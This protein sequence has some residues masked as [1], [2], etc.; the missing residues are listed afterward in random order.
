M[1]TSNRTFPW[2]WMAL[3]SLLVSCAAPQAPV[4]TTPAREYQAHPLEK[5][6]AS[7]ESSAESKVRE[8][9]QQ[10]ADALGNGDVK[11]YAEAMPIR[12]FLL[13]L[14]DHST[15]DSNEREI[16]WQSYHKALLTKMSDDARS[17]ASSEIKIV[18]LHSWGPGQDTIGAV[19][20]YV[21]ENSEIN[22][23]EW[24]FVRDNLQTL[25]DIR[26]FYSGLWL[27]ESLSNLIQLLGSSLGNKVATSDSARAA[28]RVLW[29]V[30]SMVKAKDYS[31][32]ARWYLAL[33]PKQ[34]QSAFYRGLTVE[35]L[36]GMPEYYQEKVITT[37]TQN[38]QD[39]GRYALLLA[40][41]WTNHGQFAKGMEALNMLDPK[42]G[43][44]AGIHLIRARLYYTQKQYKQSAHYF[45]MALTH[46]K[47][48]K[49]AW[50]ELLEI[51]ALAEEWELVAQ[52][53][54]TLPGWMDLEFDEKVLREQKS[55]QPFFQ[56]EAYR[57]Y[58]ARK[59]MVTEE[60]P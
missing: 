45:A 40:Q 28:Q 33:N 16:V 34:Q 41:H 47:K 15:L 30:T 46:D 18:S 10:I 14:L 5:R 32:I 26:N 21:H 60:T 20:R 43:D 38:L 42:V 44:P 19:I 51:L 37:M 12:P 11:P 53:L 7:A 6:S 13:A 1:K 9:V 2:F 17:L 54:E 23:Q 48:W 27:R 35:N 49:L 8:R 57:K 25:Y 58:A 24:V 31:N 39:S 50:F 36:A 59:Q 52:T 22:Y 29:Q 55:W 4:T 3:A 56:T